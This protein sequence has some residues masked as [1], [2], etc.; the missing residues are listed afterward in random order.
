MGDTST[1]APEGTRP[2][3]KA[4]LL[5]VLLLLG[6]VLGA[7]CPYSDAFIS[8]NERPRLLQA[9]AIVDTGE[10][11]IDGPAARGLDVGADV[12][13]ARFDGARL[14]PNKPPGATVPT[15]VAYA[16]TRALASGDTITLSAYMAVAR[17]LGGVVP[18]LIL[19]WVF[20]RRFGP[21]FSTPAVVA[22]GIVYA[23]A[24]PVA[25]YATVLYGHQLTACLLFCGVVVLVGKPEQRP[26]LVATFFG[27][28]C[29]AAAVTVEYGAVFA[30][31][32]IAVFLL[33]RGQEPGG[34]RRVLCA[35]AG[36]LVPIGALAAYQD[37][38]FGS[39][40][41][42]SYHHVVTAEFADKHGQGLLGLQ[43]PTTQSL[44]EVLTSPWGGLFV[45]AP[46][47]VLAVVIAIVDAN[48]PAA[49]ST[50]ESSEVAAHDHRQE[51]RLHLSIFVVWLVV[52]LGLTQTGGWRVGP[53]YLV[54]GFPFALLGLTA[55]INRARTRPLLL[56]I[57]AALATC[58][59]ILNGLA[60][61]LFPHLIPEGNPLVDQLWAIID[62]G[63]TPWGL[64]GLWPVIVVSVMLV[65]IGLAATVVEEQQVP[66]PAMLA[67][68]GGTMLGLV[69]VLGNA[70]V[71][72]RTARP[73]RT[74]R[75]LESFF[76]A[77]PNGTRPPVTLGPLSH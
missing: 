33:W 59:A 75:L 34:W 18:T 65:F 14:Y 51:Q 22:A 11:A 8:D 40:L 66:R 46:V 58:G 5:G 53:R 73:Q 50:L 24:T 48:K 68:L 71:V 35:L 47:I 54:A 9:M 42:T 41:S 44:Q 72:E 4:I 64:V 25:T 2:P 26:S 77:A 10:A 43:L 67:L 61:N 1:R 39:P 52:V 32:P 69:G 30:G 45:W 19:L 29:C 74:E 28:L 31:L 60:A 76:A 17:L 63:Y 3:T 21:R 13:R 23:L 15:V 6:F 27:G 57:L 7:I 20:W 62:A 38:A 70:I 12:S 16:T 37:H 55:A 36:A 56:C 49:P